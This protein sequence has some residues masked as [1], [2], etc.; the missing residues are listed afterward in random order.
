[1]TTSFDSEAGYRDAID[2]ALAAA[3]EEIRILDKDL[4]RMEIEQP[5]RVETLTAFL[6]GNRDRRLRLLL[7]DSGPL[8]RRSPRLLSLLRQ[9]GHA[10][11]VRQIPEHYRHLQEC[12][13]LADRRHGTLRFHADHPRGNLLLDAPEDIHPWW[14]R[15][16]DL[17]EQSQPCAPA[18]TLGI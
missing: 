18:T 8:E 3:R 14:Q 7:H 12:Q 9:F 6:A 15:F 17:W 1:M 5:A 11:E 4:I 10:I 16:D 2:A 13:V